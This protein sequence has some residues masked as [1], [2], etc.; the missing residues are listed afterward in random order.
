ME[1]KYYQALS[2]KLG[3]NDMLIQIA[4]PAIDKI[5]TNQLGHINDCTGDV[6]APEVA[7]D[8][9]L[10]ESWS[11]AEIFSLLVSP[12]YLEWTKDKDWFKK[13]KPFFDFIANKCNDYQEAI[14]KARELKSGLE[15][16]ALEQWDLC[17]ILSF[18]GVAELPHWAEVYVEDYIS[19]YEAYLEEQRMNELYAPS[20]DEPWWNK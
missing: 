4:V 15:C 3:W 20:D 8:A 5:V 18:W 9:L 17:D 16:C 12:D 11:P 6:L 14:K 2:K 13:V 7:V 19:Q 10:L 1:A